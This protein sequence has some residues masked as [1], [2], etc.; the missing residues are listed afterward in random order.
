MLWSASKQSPWGA[1][2]VLGSCTK[3]KSELLSVELDVVCSRVHGCQANSIE[4]YTEA[5]TKYGST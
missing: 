3:I 1:V 2:G 5:D 4:N